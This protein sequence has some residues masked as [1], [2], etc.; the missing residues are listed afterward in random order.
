MTYNLNSSEI[1]IALQKRQ[2]HYCSVVCNP[3]ITVTELKYLKANWDV[4]AVFKV[5]SPRRNTVDN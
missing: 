3:L 1:F 4:T 5:L 2:E